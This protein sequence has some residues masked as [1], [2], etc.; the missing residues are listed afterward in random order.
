MLWN[1]EKWVGDFEKLRCF[2]LTI[3]LFTKNFV[4]LKL[5]GKF[6]LYAIQYKISNPFQY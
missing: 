3:K 5:I 6:V 2:T 1:Y 4:V